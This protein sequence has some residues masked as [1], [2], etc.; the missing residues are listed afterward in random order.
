MPAEAAGICPDANPGDNLD[1]DVSRSGASAS[2][3]LVGRRLTETVA[4]G[5]AKI[6]A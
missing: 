1:R 2:L 3:R 5:M 6:T 4:V